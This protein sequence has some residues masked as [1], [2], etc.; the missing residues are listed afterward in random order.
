MA[1]TMT[2]NGVPND[3]LPNA[4]PVTLIIAIPMYDFA[5]LVQLALT[6]IPQY[7]HIRIPLL[8]FP[9]PD[10][11]NHHRLLLRL[12]CNGLL[13]IP[14]IPDLRHLAMRAIRLPL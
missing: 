12:P 13:R 9:A 11:Q 10:P 14:S 7:K 2:L 5:F 8:R 6:N 1:S 3:L 4:N